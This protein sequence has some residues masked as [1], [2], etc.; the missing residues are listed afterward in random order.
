MLHVQL[1][2]C[3]LVICHRLVIVSA[4]DDFGNGWMLEWT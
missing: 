2:C 4:L 3:T 1:I